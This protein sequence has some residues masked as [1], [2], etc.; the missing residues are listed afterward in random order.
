MQRANGNWENWEELNKNTAHKL[1]HNHSVGSTP[2]CGL[3]NTGVLK[4]RKS[5][6]S[7]RQRETYAEVRETIL[8]NSASISRKQVSHSFFFW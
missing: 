1:I 4:T 6:N 8:G 2:C 3:G 5:Q 7:E